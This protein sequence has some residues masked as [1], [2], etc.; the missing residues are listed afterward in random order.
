MHHCL[1]DLAITSIA[2]Y[3]EPILMVICFPHMYKTWS[4]II[5]HMKYNLQP[6]TVCSP[7]ITVFNNLFNELFL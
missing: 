3:T 5:I 1:K 6:V 7:S 2:S 4:D